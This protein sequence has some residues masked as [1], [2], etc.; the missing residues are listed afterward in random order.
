MELPKGSSPLLHAIRQGHPTTIA[1]FFLS[2]GADIHATLG[3]DKKTALHLAA[4][5]GNVGLLRNLI[6]RG[7]NLEARTKNKGETPLLAA[8]RHT[9]SDCWK[10][11]RV[12]LNAGANIE[13]R[14]KDGQNILHL[15]AS[16]GSI[17]VLRRALRHG[18]DPDSLTPLAIAA[19]YGEL[20]LI[21]ILLRW[22][23]SIDARCNKN[24]TPLHV[25]AAQG[26]WQNVGLL[27][28]N[29]ASLDLLNSRGYSPLQEAR[30]HDRKAA[31]TILLLAGAAE[32]SRSEKAS[33]R[34]RPAPDSSD[35]AD[36]KIRR[37]GN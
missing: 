10:A 29:G 15:V 9:S 18:L 6:R 34:K 1:E 35:E 22:G 12:L 32:N 4:S 23:A 25:A 37:Y 36:D 19:K 28:E 14:R 13:S 16:V 17:P 24:Y 5:R 21:S 30:N 2:R 26:P 3:K 31:E 7:A 11:V 20:Q 33:S 27:V 8:V